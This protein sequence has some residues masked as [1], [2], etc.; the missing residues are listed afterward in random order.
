MALGLLVLV[1]LI[2]KIIPMN[3]FVMDQVQMIVMTIW[4]M[5][6]MILLNAMTMMMMVVVEYAGGENDD[7]M[8]NK[9]TSKQF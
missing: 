9:Q 5:M 2:H 3:V 8:F 4:M 7:Y 6:W 1:D